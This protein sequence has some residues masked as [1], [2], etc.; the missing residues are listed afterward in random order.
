MLHAA[1]ELLPFEQALHDSLPLIHAMPPP[2]CPAP[3]SAFGCTPVLLRYDGDLL[4][5]APAELGAP[6][7]LVLVDL[8]AAK[9]TVAI[10]AALQVR[11]VGV[12]AGE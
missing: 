5:V 12:W 9:D 1:G 3:H 11:G 10:L 7:H 6:L 2:C 8:R 4:S